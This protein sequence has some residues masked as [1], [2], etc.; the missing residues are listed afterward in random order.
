MSAFNDTEQYTVSSYL[1]PFKA[2][3]AVR[4]SATQLHI[5][6]VGSNSVLGPILK[7][8]LLATSVLMTR[9]F[10]VGLQAADGV[11][12]TDNL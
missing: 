9:P 4:S 3:L 8:G 1:F 12:V 6:S 7:L 11:S 2:L 5:N 10:L